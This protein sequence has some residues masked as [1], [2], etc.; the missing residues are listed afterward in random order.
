MQ[1]ACQTVSR[2]ILKYNIINNNDNIRD[3]NNNNDNNNDYNN[4]DNNNDNNNNN[5]STN[6]VPL[7]RLLFPS[8]KNPEGG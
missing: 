1:D 8:V 5:D 6:L 3:D 2:F 7:Q 4:N